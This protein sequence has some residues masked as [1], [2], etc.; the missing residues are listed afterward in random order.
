VL[1][2]GIILA[3]LSEA[4]PIAVVRIGAVEPSRAKLLE[5]ELGRFLPVEVVA[6]DSLALPDGAYDPR[7][8]QYLA[9]AILAQFKSPANRLV[10]AI[11]AVDLYTPGLN[12]VFGQADVRSRCAVISTARLD[13][14]AYGLSPDEELFARRLVTEA[15]HEVGHVLG[16]GHCT[17]P[18]CVMYFSNSL[19][20]TD[21]KGPGLCPACRAKLARG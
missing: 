12:F 19:S 3:L 8:E 2:T 16:L 18:A 14:R 11:V 9:A 7:R 5:A 4:T 17:N 15:V 1:T 6:N 10:L 21:R 13:P 20:D